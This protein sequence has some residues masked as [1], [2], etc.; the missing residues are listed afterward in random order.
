MVIEFVE[1]EKKCPQGK[2]NE[3]GKCDGRLVAV[4]SRLL[5]NTASRQ[6]MCRQNREGRVEL[7][8]LKKYYAPGSKAWKTAHHTE[9]TRRV[10]A[11]TRKGEMEVSV[12]SC[13][14]R[15]EAQ[16]RRGRGQGRRRSEESC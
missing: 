9:W 12:K 8:R 16:N 13:A 2:V 6:S 4:P 5:W 3:I 14:L 7:Y 10:A 15:L 11:G 1:S